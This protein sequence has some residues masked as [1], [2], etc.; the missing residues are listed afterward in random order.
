M[1]S[2]EREAIGL[3]PLCG[4]AMYDDDQVALKV[5][6]WKI[7]AKPAFSGW[8]LSDPP[9]HAHVL[10]VEQEAEKYS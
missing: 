9:E 8:R 6:N 5:Y 4:R 7:G 3:C 2:T 10:C 1:P